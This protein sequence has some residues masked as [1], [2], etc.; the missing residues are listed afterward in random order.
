MSD[1]PSAWSYRV[2][3]IGWVGLGWYFS[4]CRGLGLIA[5]Q[6]NCLYHCGGLHNWLPCQITLELGD[7]SWLT[8]INIYIYITLFRLLDGSNTHRPLYTWILRDGSTSIGLELREHLGWGVRHVLSRKCHSKA[9][10]LANAHVKLFL[11]YFW[12]A[13]FKTPKQNIVYTY[14]Y[15]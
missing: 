12:N 13:V 3:F 4:T 11:I 5:S 2:G 6:I 9:V 15:I 14:I 7:F 8:E 1:V 10:A